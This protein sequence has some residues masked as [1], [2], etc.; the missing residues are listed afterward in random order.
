MPRHWNKILYLKNRLSWIPSLY[1][2]CRGKIK[3]LESTIT[4]KNTWNEL[5]VL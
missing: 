4:F 3:L 2:L 5:H 1:I